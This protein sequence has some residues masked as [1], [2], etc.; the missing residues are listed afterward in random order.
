MTAFLAALAA[1]FL[2]GTYGFWTLIF[3]AL[4]VATALEENEHGVLAFLTL[5]GA[6]WAGQLLKPVGISAIHHPGTALIYIAAYFSFGT[7]WGVAKWALFVRNQLEKFNEFKTKWLA[8]REIRIKNRGLNSADENDRYFEDGLRANRIEF[9]P[10]VS[11]HKEDILRWMT[12]WPLSFVWTMISDPITKIFRHIYYS[13]QSTLQRISD[14]MFAKADMK[15][16]PP[17]STTTYDMSGKKSG[18]I[19][20]SI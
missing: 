12:Y 10:Q 4:I 14:R 16:P 18:G 1:F 8:D 6:L 7:A 15:L 20:R 11:D 9:N 17:T 3:L 2:F 5:V 13:I 19:D